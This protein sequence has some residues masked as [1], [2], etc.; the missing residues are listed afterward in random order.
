MRART[1]FY[2]DNGDD[3]PDKGNLTE[4]RVWDSYKGGTARA[5]SNPLTSTNSISTFNTF[6][7]YGNILTTTDANNVVTTITYGCIDGNEI[8]SKV[9]EM[10]R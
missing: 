8:V 4:T 6:D 3:T 7:T 5:Y 10:G 1:E 9:V 2:Y